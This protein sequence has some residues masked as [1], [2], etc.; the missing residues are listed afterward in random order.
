MH[1]T[2]QQLVKVSSCAATANLHVLFVRLCQ[3]LCSQ[4]CQ[5]HNLLLQVKAGG[6]HADGL[7]LHF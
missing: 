5:E 4:Q 2:N 7:P 6:D 1:E 3:T